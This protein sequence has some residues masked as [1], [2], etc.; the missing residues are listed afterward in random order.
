MTQIRTDRL[1]L[2]TLTRE[3]AAAIRAGDRTAR[4]WAED[5]PTEGDVLVASIVGEAG[6]HYDESA[7]FGVL[8]VRLRSTGEAVGGIGFLFA[9]DED[10][11]AEVGYGIAESVR[12]QGLASEALRAVCAFA[13]ERGLRSV[14]ALTAP[15]NAASHGVLV[16]AGFTRGGILDVPDEGPMIQWARTLE[17]EFI[18]R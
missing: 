2:T 5:Y 17:D 18:A 16:K 3:E 11:S 7:T 14:T 4:A 1:L 10:G 9:P 12:R 13:A 6:E 15:G 8:Q